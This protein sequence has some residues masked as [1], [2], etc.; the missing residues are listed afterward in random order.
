MPSGYLDKNVLRNSQLCP[1]GLLT[2]CLPSTLQTL[3]SLEIRFRYMKSSPLFGPDVIMEKLDIFVNFR[4]GYL[5]LPPRELDL[6]VENF[7][8]SCPDQTF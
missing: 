1:T 4:L 3:Q 8:S 2:R 6:L 5:K 7:K